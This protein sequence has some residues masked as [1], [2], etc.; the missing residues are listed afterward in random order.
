MNKIFIFIGPHSEFESFVKK[1]SLGEKKT[2][3]SLV[4]EID[5]L[6]RRHLH[7]TAEQVA[8]LDVEEKPIIDNLVI[9][10]D[11]YSSVKEHVI[12]NIEGF[13][14]SV[15]VINIFFQNPP[16]ILHDKIINSYNEVIL[17]KFE[18]KSLS[19]KTLIS[20]KNKFDSVII[21][22]NNAKNKLLKALISQV[23]SNNKEPLVIMFF[24]PSGVGKTETAKFISRQLGGEILRKQMSMFQ[25]NDFMSYLFGSTIHDKS[26]SKDLLDRK[27][28][29]ILLDEFD[30][31][32][33][34][35]HSAFYQLF[36][37]GLFVDSNYSVNLG[38][39]II[40][41]TSNYTDLEDIKK[42]LGD[43]IFS[44][45]DSFIEFEPLSAKGVLEIVNN[46]AKVEYDKLND[47][48]KSY[49]D[50]NEIIKL[51]DSYANELKNVREIQSLIRELISGQILD[52]II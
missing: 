46:I 18:Y 45:F 27:T 43:P 51:F 41:C 6:N 10:S 29:V 12:F 38:T 25:S 47:E 16:K 36:D 1:E 30:K 42:H 3:S 15:N 7:L 48:A 2:L 33:T 50:I 19:K 31:S 39:P 28:N 5:E 13:L 14:S 23:Y 32:N 4:K 37:E 20:I 22:Q 26:F 34:V 9:Y 8:E 21:D 40:I 11:E 49:V 24:G 44:R 52:N 17:K 35:F